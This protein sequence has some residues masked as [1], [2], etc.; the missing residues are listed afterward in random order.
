MEIFFGDPLINLIESLNPAN[1]GCD[2]E[3]YQDIHVLLGG[4][5]II[6]F[7]SLKRHSTNDVFPAALG[8]AMMSLDE[9]R[10]GNKGA[11]Q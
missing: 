10:N 9:L 8:P 4:G 6:S 7:A 11:D 2:S 3:Y 1:Q 5:C